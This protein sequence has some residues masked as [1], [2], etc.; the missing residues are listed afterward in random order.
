MN[1]LLS[2]QTFKKQMK[3]VKMNEDEKQLSFSLCINTNHDIN[4]TIIEQVEQYINSL[5][6]NDYIDADKFEANIKDKEA[7]MKERIKQ[8]KENIKLKAKQEKEELK[9]KA[10]QEK[11]QSKSK[12]KKR[13]LGEE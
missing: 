1:S 4:K 3:Y 10:K 13:V 6:I 9:L 8:E 12:N 2:N 5:V 7:R 11:E